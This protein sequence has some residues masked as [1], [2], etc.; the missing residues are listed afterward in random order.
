MSFLLIVFVI[1]TI[2]SH[3]RY[4][5]LKDKIVNDC[6]YGHGA[7]TLLNG[8]E[9]IINFNHAYI[10][11]IFTNIILLHFN[12]RIIRNGTLLFYIPMSIFV[13]LSLGSPL[14]MITEI[15][16]LTDELVIYRKNSDYDKFYK[17]YAAE[18]AVTFILYSVLVHI[19]QPPLAF[20]I[21]IVLWIITGY[22]LGMGGLLDLS[23]IN[24]MG[25]LHG[26][27]AASQTKK[28]FSEWP[29]RI[30]RGLFTSKGREIFF[31]E[32]RSNTKHICKSVM[33]LLNS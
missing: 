31:K 29:K 18:G 15:K 30:F 5:K 23:G 20:K 6:I 33:S 32:L 2:Y 3:S 14:Y 17:G 1:F 28:M 26:N 19:A 10:V 27:Y 21:I 16:H 9:N 22:V 8:L 7:R 25:I 12:I 11:I 4:K 24:D 13:I